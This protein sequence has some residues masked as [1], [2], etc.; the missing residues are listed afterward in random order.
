M[1]NI[2]DGIKM[3]DGVKVLSK[4]VQI[5]N[6]SQMRDLADKFKTKIGSGVVLL[7][8]SPEESTFDRVVTKDITDRFHAGNIVKAAAAH[9][10][11][12]GAEDRT[13]PRPVGQ[14]LKTWNRPWHRY[15]ISKPQ[16]RD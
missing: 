7:G 9:V 8:P 16:L 6:P 10:G 3:I 15:T 2:D 11:G 1:E 12:G 5:D 14:N 13:W 4:K